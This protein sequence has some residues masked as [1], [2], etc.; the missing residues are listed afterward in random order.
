MTQKLG[1][2]IR[3]DDED[4][5]RLARWAEN[6]NYPTSAFA[7]LMLQRAIQDRV[8]W[9]AYKKKEEPN[10]IKFAVAVSAADAEAVSKLMAKVAAKV[11]GRDVPVEQIVGN[12]VY[13][14]LEI[15]QFGR[16]ALDRPKWPPHPVNPCV[17]HATLAPLEYESFVEIADTCFETLEA[18]ASALFKLGLTA[19]LE[20]YMPKAAS[21]DS[22]PN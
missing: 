17:I 2:T 21:R 7:G 3:L 14:G 4:R 13:E 22:R 20:R 16:I 5:R 6:N 19:Y 9:E 1:L 18:A 10:L 11:G 15:E 8:R 12:I